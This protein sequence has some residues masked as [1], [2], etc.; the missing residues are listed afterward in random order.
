MMDFLSS[1]AEAFLCLI[2]G[3]IVLAIVLAIVPGD[4]PRVL[5]RTEEVP[6]RRGHAR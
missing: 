2:A 3:A 1:A 4:R 6:V 5:A